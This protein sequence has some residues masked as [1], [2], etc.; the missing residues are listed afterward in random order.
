MA[1]EAVTFTRTA[2]VSQLLVSTV[3][4]VVTS[5]FTRRVEAVPPRR[6]LERPVLVTE[7]RVVG[8]LDVLLEEE[9][10]PARV[11]YALAEV[12]QVPQRVGRLQVGGGWW[13]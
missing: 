10:L 6:L 9:A 7:K 5:V 1:H 8:Q 2:A 4:L 13:Q 11:R 12:H 3:K